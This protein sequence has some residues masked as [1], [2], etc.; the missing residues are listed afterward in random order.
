[1]RTA[2]L[3]AWQQL[4]LLFASALIFAGAASA[5]LIIPGTAASK[6]P[7]PVAAPAPSKTEIERAAF[8]ACANARTVTPCRSY[9]Q[10]FPKGN[11]A[12]TARARIADI[13]AARAA[14]A[15]RSAEAAAPPVDREPQAWNACDAASSVGPC[16]RYIAAF[17]AGPR[18]NDAR[19]RIASLNAATQERTAFAACQAS[20]AP[21]PCEAYLATYPAGASAA[22]A[23]AQV[24]AIERNA[25][26]RAAVAQAEAAQRAAV[27]KDAAAQRAA[28]ALALAAAEKEKTAFAPC[29]DGGTAAACQAYLDSFPGGAFAAQARVKMSTLAA[30]DQ[31]R[32][33]AGA[34]INGNSIALCEKYL[35]AYPAGG[36][37]AAV[38]ARIAALTSAE[39]ERATWKLCEVGD[40]AV[41]CD[42]YLASY[43]TGASA[44]AARAIIA[45][46]NKDEASKRAAEAEQAAWDQCRTT[47]SNILPCQQYLET[48]PAGRF[49]S[50]AKAQIDVIATGPTEDQAVPALG[51]VVKRNAQ[52]QL[53]VVSVQGNSTAMGNVFGGDVIT[54]INDKPYDPRIAPRAALEA[55]IAQDNGRVEILI[56]RGAV[57]VSKVLRARR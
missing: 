45:R 48:Y 14:A 26:Q 52:S 51:L 13:E 19:S 41:Q 10:Q 37:A 16:E 53:V 43:P 9:L 39:Q 27:E 54:T 35:A 40:S 49:A 31:E 18:V 3:S 50:L 15:Q 1:M 17:P 57:P 8:N 30:A 4:V 6:P 22:A 36:S 5:Q 7:P 21:G 34:C 38:R 32:A 24:A 47:A 56:K 12:D 28:A 2:A 29:L 20:T 55:A 23:K 11:F 46:I 33:G 44:D 25:G 42:K